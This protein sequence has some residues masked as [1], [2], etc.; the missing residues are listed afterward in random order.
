MKQDLRNRAL[1]G[2]LIV[3]TVTLVCVARFLFQ[4]NVSLNCPIKS[5][6]GL[7]CPGCGSTRCVVALGSGH[8]TEAFRQNA[9]LFAATLLTLVYGL[10]GL[11]S[12]RSAIGV[13]RKVDQNIHVVSWI[14]LAVVGVFTVSR[15]I[16]VVS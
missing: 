3:G 10:I 5:V 13:V 4:H 16:P 14:L 6:T 15:N 8:F 7:K 11:V 1:F 9:L 2:S 12:P